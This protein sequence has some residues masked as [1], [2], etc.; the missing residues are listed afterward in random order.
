MAAS[1]SAE[2][3]ADVG[4]CPF[5]AVKVR[6]QTNPQFARGLMVS[7]MLVFV[8]NDSVHR[9]SPFATD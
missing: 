8:S 2:V 3:I 5:E 6:I 9:I 7:I 1:A 4:L